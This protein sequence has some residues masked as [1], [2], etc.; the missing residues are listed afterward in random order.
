[1]SGENCPLVLACSFHCDHQ[2]SH[3]Q[4]SLQDMYRKEEL[5]DLNILVGKMVIRVHMVIMA[6][7]SP[8]LRNVINSDLGYNDRIANIPLHQLNCEAVK[9]LVKF[10][11]TSDISVD[12][13]SAR[14]LLEAAQVLKITEV[15]QL[16]ET[17]LSAQ[18]RFHPLIEAEKTLKQTPSK[19]S[20]LEISWNS[21]QNSNVSMNIN[22]N[23]SSEPQQMEVERGQNPASREHSGDENISESSPLTVDPSFFK[24]PRIGRGG[25]GVD[26][27]GHLLPRKYHKRPPGLLPFNKSTFTEHIRESTHLVSTNKKQLQNQMQ[28]G[29][30]TGM[31]LT[32]ESSNINLHTSDDQRTHSQPQQDSVSKNSTCDNRSQ[33]EKSMVK[34]VYSDMAHGCITY[35]GKRGLDVDT[36]ISIE[37]SNLSRTVSYTYQ[38]SSPITS[39]VNTTHQKSESHCEVQLDNI[40]SSG[41]TTETIT[42]S[43][44]VLTVG[45]D[46]SRPSIESPK[47]E[48]MLLPTIHPEVSDL[49]PFELDEVRSREIISHPSQA[50][51]VSSPGLGQD[52]SATVTPASSIYDQKEDSAPYAA[53]KENEKISGE[54]MDA[55]IE[56]IQ[57]KFEPQDEDVIVTDLSF[58]FNAENSSHANVPNQSAHNIISTQPEI[59]HLAALIPPDNSDIHCPLCGEKFSSQVSLAG[60]LSTHY[61][62]SQRDMFPSLPS[63]G[64]FTRPFQSRP[65]AQGFVY[66]RSSSNQPQSENSVMCGI[67][68]Q[69]YKDKASLRFHKRTHIKK[70]MCA[71]CGK[72]FS[73]AGNLHR[74]CRTHSGERSYQCYICGRCF[75]GASELQVHLQNHVGNSGFSC[76][77]C[78]E[79]FNSVS[80]LQQHVRNVHGDGVGIKS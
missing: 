53:S 13:N 30:V 25:R 4:E 11:Y 14:P 55:D 66:R 69:Y 60:H 63:G 65:H 31:R 33:S 12:S 34:T 74:H 49:N 21:I 41:E 32:S 5:L 52:R 36:I 29:Q 79:S 16:C 57:V 3:L 75:G 39:S 20:E 23:T 43:H 1:M 71:Q 35:P 15:E 47:Q 2:K 10:C 28:K 54:V 8:Y 40:V 46:D 6:A 80:S 22:G 37:D 73:H 27:H 61:S 19:S 59:S 50:S 45:N 17:F 7:F 70:Y 58:P 62:Q 72:R 77:R 68:G 78:G 67:C 18:Q 56:I 44:A 76:N 42:V 38:E 26:K 9:A 51:T 48:T 24:Y 64:T